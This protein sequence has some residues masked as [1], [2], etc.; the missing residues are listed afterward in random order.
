[1]SQR[2][3]RGGTDTS[4]GPGDHGDP[5]V[6]AEP[7]EHTHGP[8]ITTSPAGRGGTVQQSLIV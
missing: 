7:I 1:L 8:K 5:T 6:K 3:G 2:D 4:S